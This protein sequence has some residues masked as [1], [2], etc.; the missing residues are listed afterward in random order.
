MKRIV[1]I[2]LTFI[3]L[4]LGALIVFTNPFDLA[5]III[6]MFLVSMSIL[7]LAIQVYF[8]PSQ[9]EPVELKVIEQP[10][11]QSKPLEVKKAKKSKRRKKYVK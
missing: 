8:P 2:V 4:M 1:T 7:N 10:I 5:A 6:G 11:E 9:E 3:V